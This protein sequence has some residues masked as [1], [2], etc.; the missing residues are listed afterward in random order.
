MK[1]TINL[2]VGDPAG[3]PHPFLVE[4][5]HE[6]IQHAEAN[7]YANP[8]GLLETR[9]AVVRYYGMQHNIAIQPDNV[10]ICHGA[11][12]AIRLAL[13]AIGRRGS[14]CGHLS[15]Q[16]AY[17]GSLIQDAGMIPMPLNILGRELDSIQLELFFAGLAGGVFLL[18]A[19]HNPTGAVLSDDVLTTIVQLA[20]HYDVR[21]MSDAVYLDLYEISKPSS[22]LKF[23]NNCIEIIS[24]SKPFKAC[25]YRC[26][27]VVGG[28]KEWVAAF[29]ARYAAMNGVPYAIQKVAE[30][31][32]TEMP[33]VAEFRGEIIVR[34]AVVVSVLRNLGFGIDTAAMNQG[35]MFVWAEVP[36]SF[37]TAK[38][39]VDQALGL[40]IL[41]SEG[42]SFGDTKGRHIRISLNETSNILEN[43]MHRFKLL[44]G[45]NYEAA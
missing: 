9:K 17:F 25:G 5:F 33:G 4:A 39:L 15:P 21:L 44:G 19:V 27:A 8:Q 12:P 29:A 26:G 31:A 6:A 2:A 32:W 36:K 1:F 7:H 34:R 3:L 22:L 24:L 42:T 23:T 38:S 45:I 41:I 37:A 35:G 40:G 13:D 11:R 30:R 20:D 10:A 18:N 28:D 43:A 16:Y 14:G